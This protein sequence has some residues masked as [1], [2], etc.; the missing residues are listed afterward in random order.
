MRRLSCFVLLADYWLYE[1]GKELAGIADEHRRET[2]DRLDSSALYHAG[3][4]W[5]G[6]IKANGCI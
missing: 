4:E 3:M 6:I 2:F 1:T 5:S